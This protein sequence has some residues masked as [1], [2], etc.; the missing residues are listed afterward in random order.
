MAA[1]VEEVEAAGDA[2]EQARHLYRES[3]AA[4][5]PLSGRTLGERFGRSDRWGRRRIAEVRAEGADGAAGRAAVR[6]Q[7]A[8]SEAEPAAVR[9]EGADSEAE[10]AAVRAERAQRRGGPGRNNGSTNGGRSSGE[11]RPFELPVSGGRSAESDAERTAVIPAAA[12]PPAPAAVRAEPADSAAPPAAVRAE[13]ADSEAAPADIWAEPADVRAAPADIR[14]EPADTR[15]APAAVR[16]EPA[17]TRAE[18]A[19]SEA[20]PAVVRAE[21]AAAVA[22]PRWVMATAWVAVGVVAAVAAV[23]SFEH[24]RELAERSGESWRSWLLPLSVDGLIVA[25]SLVMYVRNRLNERVGA[26]PWLALLGGLV[27]SVAAN[28]G[29]ALLP[30]AGQPVAVEVRMAVAGFPPVALIVAAELLMQLVR[31][32][33]GQERARKR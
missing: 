29:T 26:L 17:D 30:P 23:V 21:P 20:A 7:G 32:S 28:V 2:A 8:D 22:V 33:S 4:E 25:G 14:A 6:A 9:A 15:A 11:W 19:D 10:P 27:V 24:M 13:P 16:A 1:E 31:Q 18:P 5:L 12:R 3:V